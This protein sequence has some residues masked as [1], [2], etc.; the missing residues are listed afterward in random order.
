[1]K[2]R[3]VYV[4]MCYY[5]KVN[6]IFY[7]DYQFIIMNVFIDAMYMKFIYIKLII[8]EVSIYFCFCY[9]KYVEFFRQQL[10]FN[11][12]KFKFS[13]I[14]GVYVFNFGISLMFFSQ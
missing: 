6:V 9:E 8:V 4:E 7:E 10:I 12:V 1:M 11:I 2:I 14:I 13:N 3:Q 5:M